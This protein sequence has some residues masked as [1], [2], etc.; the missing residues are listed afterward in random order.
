M[1]T[2]TPTLE[3]QDIIDKSINNNVLVINAGSGCGKTQTLSMVAEAN[4]VKS[5]MLVFNKSNKEDAEDRFP[6]HVEIRTTHSLAY[7][8]VGHKYRHKLSR[9][10]GAY[11]NVVY[12]GGEIAKF[13]NIKG[14]SLEDNKYVSAAGVGF[15]IRR[16]VELFEQSDSFSIKSK[17]IPKEAKE[18]GIEDFILGYAKE[19][20]GLRVDINSKVMMSHDTYMKLYQLSRPTLPHK[21]IYLDEAQ[22]TSACT[23]DIVLRQVKRA[24]IIVVGDRRQSIYS[25]RGSINAMNVVKGIDMLLSESFRFGPDSSELANKILQQTTLR[26]AKGVN[27]VV[28]RNGVVNRSEPYTMLFRTN[29]AL[30][31]K[32]LGELKRGLKVNLEINTT[33]LCKQL[34]DA[35]RLYEGDVGKVKHESLLMFNY[36]VELKQEAKHNPELNR[37]ANLIEGG[38][39]GNVLKS[40]KNHK[41][42][43]T[44]DIIMTTAH[45]SKGREWPQVVLGDDFPSNFNKEGE[46][47]GLHK[48]EQNLLYVALT[49][50]RNRLEYNNSVLEI[51]NRGVDN[52]GH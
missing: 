31:L 26:S 24:K 14:I 52:N 43:K 50:A 25:W 22:D 1:I 29:V 6:P 17:H 42:C 44:P 9:P 40:L 49:R 23:L 46:W 3:Q 2:Y 51:I 47:V 35:V 20:W 34:Q 21:I 18:K 4:K 7:G 16:C 12:T 5:L 36:W 41:N 28:G 10:K 11:V 30:L 13:F 27:T 8:V 19:L 45:K 33:D 48:F 37:I 38:E 32:A 39:V 15:L